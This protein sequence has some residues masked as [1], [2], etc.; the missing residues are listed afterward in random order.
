MRAFKRLES[1]FMLV[2]SVGI[3]TTL[4]DPVG[5]HRMPCPLTGQQIQLLGSQEGHVVTR[6]FGFSV[7]FHSRDLTLTR[8]E[9]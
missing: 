7:L 6:T 8:T 2:Q 4:W 5:P 3:C 9:V 1:R